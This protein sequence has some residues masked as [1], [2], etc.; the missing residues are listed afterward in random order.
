M[1]LVAF[2]L[3]A[4]LILAWLVSPGEAKSVLTSP[5]IEP[6]LEPTASPAD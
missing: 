5:G 1:I 6:S 2:I 4:V 3:F